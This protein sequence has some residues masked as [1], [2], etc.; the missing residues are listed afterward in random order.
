MG[1]PFSGTADAEVSG[2]GTYLVPGG[3]FLLEVKKTIFKETRKSGPAFICEFEVIESDK[4]EDHPIGSSATFFQSM[5][6]R[7]V[8][9]PSIK[10]FM[11]K[12]CQADGL[13]KEDQDEFLKT[14]DDTLNEACEAET[15]F[16]GFRVRVKTE[17]HTTL[18]GGDFTRH[19]WIA[20]DGEQ[21]SIEE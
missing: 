3:T 6:D 8:A 20:Y 11:M 1:N 7:S 12:L 2:R 17:H 16:E 21:P 15:T 10:D 18:K 19:N 13:D 14:L 4:P 5:R 9:L